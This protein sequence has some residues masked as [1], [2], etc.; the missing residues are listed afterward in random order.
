[1]RKHRKKTHYRK[2]AVAVGALAMVGVPT[3]AMACLDPQETGPAHTAAAAWRDPALG[4]PQAQ[5][6]AH[7]PVELPRAVPPA[8]VEPVVE[9]SAEQA[10]DTPPPAA[11]PRPAAPPAEPAAAP[12]APQASGAPADVQAAVVALVNQERAA[13]GCPAVTVNP[14]LTQAAQD[15][16]ADMAAHATMSHTGS[17]GSDPGGRITRAGYQW[18]TYGEN[19]AYGYDT[20]EQV[21]EGWMNSPGHRRNILDCSYRE[22]GIGLA[23]PGQYWTQDFGA[24]R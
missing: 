12:P 2:I 21:M 10:V 15:H 3:A 17:D 20:P 8:P 18:Q 23:Q 6:R 14:M 16:S 13:A 1:M 9:P 5:P 22:I 7:T 19:V 11:A 4:G 24:T